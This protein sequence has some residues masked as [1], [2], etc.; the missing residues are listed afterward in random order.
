MVATL[1]PKPNARAV[2]EPKARSFW[3]F[4]RD[5]QA[6]LT[7]DGVDPVMADVPAL[8]IQEP[9]DLTVTITTVLFGYL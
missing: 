4:L 3:L 6:L 2:R 5:L 8:E 7:P 1:G 9:R